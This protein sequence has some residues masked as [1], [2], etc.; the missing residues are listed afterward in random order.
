MTRRERSLAVVL[1]VAALATACAAAPGNPPA[2]DPARTERIHVVR[3]VGHTGIVVAAAAVPATS[4][5]ARR[6]FADAE[7]LEVG[8]GDRDYYQA[9]EPTLWMGARALFWPTPSALQVA[10][11][12]GPVA[13]Y[14]KEAEIV[15][16]RVTPAGL[17]RLV[18]V[19]AA[20]HELDAAG[21]P[22]RLG[23]GQYGRSRFYASRETFHLFRTCNVWTASVLREAGVAVEPARALT[24]GAL[25][26]QLRAPAQT[27]A[28][29]QTGAAKA[30]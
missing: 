21:Q 29:A 26:A 1:V 8:W 6:D 4:W 3:H 20:S 27:P 2:A 18:E 28:A 14:F 16:L 11:F 9:A 10:A 19:V 25:M 15:E 23:P 17:A 13:R 5:P 12:S 7:Y 22:I 24:A 30:Q